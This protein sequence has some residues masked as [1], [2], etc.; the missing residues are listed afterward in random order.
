[1]PSIVP[2]ADEAILEI[3][4]GQQIWVHSM[5]ATPS[6]L[7]KALADHASSVTDLSLLQLHLENAEMLRNSYLKGHIRA[8][9]FFAS[10]AT[11]PMVNRGLADYVPMMLSDIPRAIRS[12][13]Q[14]VDAALIQVSPPDRHG[15]CSLGVSVEA[16][17]AACEAAQLII[18]HVNPSMPRSHGDGFIPWDRIDSAF[19]LD[20]P[21]PEIAPAP[22]N[23]VVSAI[24]EHAASLV[25][26]RDCLQLGIGSI[27]DAVV[28]NLGHLR[29]LGVHSEMFSDGVV[30][31]VERG[32]ISNRFK[33]THPGK[34]VAGFVLGTRLVYDF[35]DDNPEVALL[36]IEYVNS[37]RTISRNDRVVSINSALQ[38]DLSGQICADSLGHEI[39]S[40]VGGQLDFVL[41]A[42]LSEGGRSI[43]ALPS[44][45][46]RGS[47]SRIV[48]ELSRGAGVVTPRASAHYV[49]TEFGV[50]ELRGRS[51]IERAQALIKIAHPAFR[52]ELSSWLATRFPG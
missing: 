41:G 3:R 37:L 45:A 6:L 4:S 25:R 9:C 12:G 49:V 13:D 35:V 18:A 10:P 43:I 20:C 5:A 15:L 34:C 44:T 40:G 32:V 17:R 21:L 30:D 47:V 38:I 16:T 33:A 24:G 31:L 27:P 19:E 2:S 28:A 23:E 42:N 1:V 50:A 29:D 14:P 11:R 22:A 8:R 48:T 26:D 51:L 36:D 52:E 7:L 46:A 39:Y